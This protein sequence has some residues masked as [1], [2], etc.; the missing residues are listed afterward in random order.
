[1]SGLWYFS[2]GKSFAGTFQKIS[3]KLHNC[4]KEHAFTLVLIALLH[5]LEIVSRNI[6]QNSEGT[7]NG[8]STSGELFMLL[9][10]LM[11]PLPPAATLVGGIL[12]PKMIL[13][14]HIVN[15][16]D[17][18]VEGLG[19]IQWPLLIKNHGYMV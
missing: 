17:K 9:L 6:Y 8:R 5:K 7:R 12:T 4:E 3:W 1:M 15:K 2:L 16:Y 10:L 14:N 18:G 19:T 11:L 13:D